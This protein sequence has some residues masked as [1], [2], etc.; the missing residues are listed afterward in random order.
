MV[1]IYYI[2]EPNKLCKHWTFMNKFWKVQFCIHNESA[3]PSSCAKM[4]RDIQQ[5][6]LNLPKSATGLAIEK[7]RDLHLRSPLILK[8]KKILLFFYPPAVM[9]EN[10][11]YLSIWRKKSLIQTQIFISLPAKYCSALLV[12]TAWKKNLSII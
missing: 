5:I 11:E 10:L 9:L 7:L 8:E 3:S 4:R 1:R 12:S 2:L 6:F